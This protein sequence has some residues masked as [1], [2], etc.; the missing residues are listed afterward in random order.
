METTVVYPPQGVLTL[1]SRAWN[2]LKVNLKSSL[3]IVLGPVVVMAVISVLLGIAASWPFLTPGSAEQQVLYILVAG[4]SMVLFVANYFVFGFCAAALARLYYSAIVLNT[5]L[6]VH[7]CWQA[8]RQKAG[9]IFLLLLVL[10]VPAF[11]FLALDLMV[12]MGGI[13][14]A[15]LVVGVSGLSGLMS[16]HALSSIFHL[17]FL[18]LWGFLI[19]GTAISLITV[20]GSFLFFPL[21]SIATEEPP[22]SWWRSLKR[23]SRLLA[24]NASRL[25]PFAGGL[26][27]FSLV[28]SVMLN[29]PPQVWAWFEKTRLGMADADRVPLYINLVVNLWDSL[30]DL[31]LIPFYIGALTLFWYDCRARK[32]GLDLQI[33][34]Q[35]MMVRRGKDPGLYLPG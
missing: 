9:A 30:I 35:N 4:F 33:R 12:L 15:T 25:I 28:V 21:L 34:L 5:P 27:C 6:A 2:M 24:T 3:L 10:I 32:E 19:L 23:A 8:T 20:Q 17:L 14:V 13:L 29:L 22:V 26:F 11:L 1:I 18:L 16:G 31:F 7:E